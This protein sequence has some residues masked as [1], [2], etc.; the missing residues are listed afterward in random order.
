[1]ASMPRD[2]LQPDPGFR[3][4]TGQFSTDRGSSMPG[5][6][7]VDL[8]DLPPAIRQL[9]AGKQAA[10]PAPPPGAPTQPQMQVNP[11]MVAG[12]IQALQA[13][14]SAGEPGDPSSTWTAGTGK[15]DY[16]QA[17]NV[18]YGAAN[19][20]QLAAANA[21][22]LAPPPP[23][24]LAPPPG[25]LAP[26]PGTLAPTAPV[27]PVYPAPAVPVAPAPSHGEQAAARLPI[28]PDVT[29]ADGHRYIEVIVPYDKARL[30]SVAA[31]KGLIVAVA[32][33][34]TFLYLSTTGTNKVTGVNAPAM[35]DVLLEA[36]DIIGVLVRFPPALGLVS[37]WLDIL[38]FVGDAPH[39]TVR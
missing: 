35:D 17:G 23:G 7:T 25:T 13:Q 5:Y 24:A 16:G 11:A 28:S 18:D 14:A 9:R 6:T 39:V 4:D 34:D 37:G 22:Q 20:I 1:M 19:M 21:Q 8:S 10:L 3:V 33:N 26:P 15:G 32:V 31:D 30:L 27:G 36:G 12:L 38:L 29:H 2:H